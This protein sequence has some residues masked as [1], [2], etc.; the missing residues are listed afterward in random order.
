[1]VYNLLSNQCPGR[2]DRLHG[3]IWSQQK[4]NPDHLMTGCQLIV[5]HLLNQFRVVV[6]SMLYG[7]IVI[8]LYGYMFIWLYVYMVICL[9]GYMF[10]WLYGHMV[11]WSSRSSMSSVGQWYQCCLLVNGI[12]VVWSLRASGRPVVW[13]SGRLVVRASMLC[14]RQERLVV[15][16][17]SRQCV[18]STMA[19]GR[20]GI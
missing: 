2:I 11:I 12:N 1:M 19:Y 15:K 4:I 14:G 8:W 7:Y 3:A 9:Y 20:P 18:R 6:E 17:C 13:S 10:I 5:I 16:A